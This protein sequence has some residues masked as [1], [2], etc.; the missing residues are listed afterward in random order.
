MRL[1]APWLMLLPLMLWRLPK[2]QTARLRSL[3]PEARFDK[4]N[5]SRKTLAQIIG[6]LFVIGSLFST[7]KTLQVSQQQVQIARGG[8]ITDRFTKAIEQLGN[9]KLEICLG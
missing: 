2:R 4:E 7:A 6:G 5:E 3:T 8:Q 1:S 9:E